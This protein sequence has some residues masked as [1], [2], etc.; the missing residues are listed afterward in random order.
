[1]DIGYNEDKKPSQPIRENERAMEIKGIAR[2][3]KMEITGPFDFEALHLLSN[4]LQVTNGENAQRQVLL[5]AAT[6][7]RTNDPVRNVVCDA[8]AKVAAY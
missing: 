3:V 1:M 5:H 7:W 2:L 6:I 8:A 4:L